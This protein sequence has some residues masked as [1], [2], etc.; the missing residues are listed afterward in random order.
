M[1]ICSDTLIQTFYLCA[2]WSRAE[3]L[4]LCAANDEDHVQRFQGDRATH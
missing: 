4:A 2:D 1:Q 3:H